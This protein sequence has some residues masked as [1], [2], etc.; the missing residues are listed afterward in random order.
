MSYDKDYV[1]Y[2]STYTYSLIE[3]KCSDKFNKELKQNIFIFVLNYSSK[4]IFT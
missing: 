3:K 4:I 1:Y 2:T